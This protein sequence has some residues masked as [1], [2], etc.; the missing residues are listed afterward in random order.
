MLER[1]RFKPT[2]AAGLVVLGLLVL[3][4]G[5]VVAT[6]RGVIDQ[7]DE[8]S[9]AADAA[10][11]K[12]ADQT[13]ALGIDKEVTGRGAQGDRGRGTDDHDRRPLRA[14]FRHR[15]AGRASPAA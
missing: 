2:L 1:H 6:V 8:I 15:H 13:D 14:G 3:M 9:A 7:A 4:A 10:L 11:D 5:V 12:A